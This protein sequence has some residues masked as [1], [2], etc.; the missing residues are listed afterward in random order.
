MENLGYY[1]GAIG[2]IEQMV[3]PMGDRACYFGDGLFEVTYTKNHIPY[4]L[5]EHMDRLYASAREL[6]IQIPLQKD[7][8]EALI[9]SLI[10]RVDA[11]EQWV[12]WQ[13]SRGTEI[14]DYPPKDHLKANVMVML[15]PMS[16][17]D[18]YS[19]MRAVTMEDRRGLYCHMKTLNVLPAV[20]ASAEA[21][22]R[23]VDEGILHRNGRVTE[24]IH[25]NLSILRK[26]GV[27]QTAPADRW[28]LA[29]VARGHLLSLAR[30]MGIPVEETPFTI[31]ELMVA[32]EIIVTSSGTLCRPIREI[33]GIPVGGKAPEILKRLQDALTEKFLRAC[34]EK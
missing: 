13:V 11:D 16:I 6:D 28:I 32:D 7:E 18:S 25:A 8:F 29:G 22:A 21:A 27:L 31:E 34:S 4:S 2:P 5:G 20:M 15:R 30:S 26:D 9:R 23:G 12:Y 10:R 19:P 33:D 3:I 17:K 24:C 14:R 1:N